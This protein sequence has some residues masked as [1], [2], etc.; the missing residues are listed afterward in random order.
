LSTQCYFEKALIAIFI[1]CVTPSKQQPTNHAYFHVSRRMRGFYLCS[2]PALGWTGLALITLVLE[3]GS[4]L[5]MSQVPRFGRPQSCLETVEW[6]VEL[7]HADGFA[8]DKKALSA[9]QWKLVTK[10]SNIDLMEKNMFLPCW[11]HY[12]AAQITVGFK[13]GAPSSPLF[14]IH[15][16]GHSPVDLIEL[17]QRL[18][19]NVDWFLNRQCFQ[20]SH[21]CSTTFLTPLKHI[22][23]QSFVMGCPFLIVNRW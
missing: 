3:P 4:L 9:S 7:L 10:K 16:T 5:D 13:K 1:G 21:T 22:K 14:P 11:Q 18:L 2:G 23:L 17:P 15:V 8:F 20:K 6:W 19:N 12:R